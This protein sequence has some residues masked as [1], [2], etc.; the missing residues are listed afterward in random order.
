MKF[1]KKAFTLTEIL[2]GLTIIGTIAAILIPGTMTNI[3]KKLL[4][5]QA[6]NGITE[7][8]QTIIDNM[9]DSKKNI[10]EA[11]DFTK[12][13]LN[14]TKTCDSTKIAECWKV[15]YKDIKGNAISIPSSAAD[16]ASAA[17]LKKGGTILIKNYTSEEDETSGEKCIEEVW[18]DINGNETPNK[19]GRDLFVFYITDKGRV[20]D[21]DKCTPPESPTSKDDLSK[22]CQ[23]TAESGA[24][25]SYCLTTLQLNNW[26]MDY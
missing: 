8:Q 11:S 15:T 17:I 14:T 26:V 7:V 4:A 16:A 25:P 1:N 3:N 5:T 6:K 2:V 13:S 20:G 19:L 9:T 18:Y 10:F 21:I 23:G 12:E 22:G 24:I